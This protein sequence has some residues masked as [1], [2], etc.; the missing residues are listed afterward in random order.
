MHINNEWF[1]QGCISYF[2]V[3]QREKKKLQK[4]PDYKTHFDQN[5]NIYI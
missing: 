5:Q 4:K 1:N 2:K 3:Y